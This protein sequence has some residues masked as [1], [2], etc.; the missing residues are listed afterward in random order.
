MPF[1]HAVTKECGHFSREEKHFVK[2]SKYPLLAMKTNC[3]HNPCP[4]YK[5]AA[6]ERP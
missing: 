3:V 6:I 2:T 1:G 4:V 5:A